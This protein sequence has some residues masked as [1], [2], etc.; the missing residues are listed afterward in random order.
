MSAQGIPLGSS[1]PPIHPAMNLPS[2]QPGPL[3]DQ[4]RSIFE[5]ASEGIFQTSPDGHY[6]RVN[7]ALAQIYGYE[8][9][10]ELIAEQP[11]FSGRL[12]VDPNRRQEFVALM[13][14]QDIIQDFESQI[15]QRDGQ[16]VWI[17][18]TCRAV[19]DQTGQLMYYEGFVRQICDRKRHEAERQAAEQALRQKHQELLATLEQLQQAKQA[20]EVANQ[21]KSNF[22]AHMSHELR[23]PLNGILGYTQI[24]M[25][26]QTLTQKHQAGVRT[27]HQC[28]THL[29]TLINDIL[30]LSKIEAQKIELN[31]QSF[32]LD[33]FLED[34]ADICRIRAQQKR[35]KFTYQALGTLPIAIEA[36]EKRLRQILLN[37][38]S[39]AIK[40]TD[41]GAVTLRVE[42]S[43]R[44]CL[45]ST[46]ASNTLYGLAFDII[47]TGLGIAPDQL[48]RVFQPFEQVGDYSHRAEGTGLGLAI[49]QQLISL[50]GGD[51]QVDSV[52]GEGSQFRFE[53]ILPGHR[54]GVIPQRA[55]SSLTHTIVGYEGNPRTILV[56]D[57]RQDNRSV[58]V[59]LLEPLG[60]HLLE[61]SNG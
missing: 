30:D 6:L 49:T 34:I 41:R 42:G 58:V 40:F 54:E 44:E 60:F 47:D 50:M 15:Y 11:N 22:L 55:S 53:L 61:A 18:E 13:A 45:R 23:T 56:V 14:N 27:I 52:P 4:Y 33:P 29:L 7:P 9:P 3:E 8:T 57:D 17:S 43:H 32:Y 5:N 46:S 19:R 37:L 36:D 48:V 31:A 26:D 38:L 10:T 51:L 24:L 25:R 35:L 20:A 16:T 2:P 39:N 59:G 12:Y 1:D 21:A 28:G